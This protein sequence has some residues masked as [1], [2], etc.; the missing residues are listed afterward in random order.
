M[1]KKKKN[2]YQ[3]PTKKSVKQKQQPQEPREPS[4]KEILFF[5]IGISVIGLAVVIIAVIFIVQYYMNLEE[6]D[7]YEE[8]M[9]ITV[10]ELVPLTKYYEQGTYVDADTLREDGYEDINKLYQNND[11]FYIYFYHSTDPNDE[12]VSAVEAN[13]GID[14]IPTLELLEDQPDKDYRALFFLDLDDTANATLF[15]NANFSH[16][17]LDTEAANMLLTFDYNASE[18]SLTIDI[19]EILATISDLQS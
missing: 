15:E 3:K 19:N 8:Y 9:V 2:Q 10:D 12:I 6:T 1:A 4:P 16:L 7:P 11:Y 5:K 17:N 14:D 18:F 13:T